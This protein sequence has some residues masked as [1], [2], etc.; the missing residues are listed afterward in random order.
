VTSADPTSAAFVVIP[1]D[2]PIPRDLLVCVRHER[3]PP[4]YPLGS[5]DDA[6]L[7]YEVV[8]RLDWP[9][10]GPGRYRIWPRWDSPQ[11]WSPQFGRAV[12]LYPFYWTVFHACNPAAFDV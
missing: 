2:P 8:D 9:G 4:T 5:R 7:W 12:R 11:I 1:A 6:M 3:A 10:W